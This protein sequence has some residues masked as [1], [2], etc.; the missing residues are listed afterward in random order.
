MSTQLIAW[1]RKKVNVGKFSILDFELAFADEGFLAMF[2]D[3]FQPI[4]DS[5]VETKSN[6]V[7]FSILEQDLERF[8]SWYRG[9][10]MIWWEEYLFL[11][12]DIIPTN[13]LQ[14]FPDEFII[15]EVA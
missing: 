1:P 7:L 12:E 9:A 3:E 10:G 5:D 6:V 2:E 13:I 14:K 4:V 15:E 8:A 11:N